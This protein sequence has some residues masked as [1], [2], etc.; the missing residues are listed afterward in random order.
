[1]TERDKRIAKAMT[2]YPEVWERV[3]S[4]CVWAAFAF[5]LDD[6]VARIVMVCCEG[7]P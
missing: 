7:S 2:L 6:H 5:D 3:R 4:V 1:V